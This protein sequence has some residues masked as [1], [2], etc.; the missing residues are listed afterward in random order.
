MM[1]KMYQVNTPSCLEERH[2]GELIQ[3]APG[4]YNMLNKWSWKQK[5][6]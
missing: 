5:K 4:E 3:V 6:T 2:A 1:G